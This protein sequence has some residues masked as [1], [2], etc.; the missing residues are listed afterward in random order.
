MLEGITY[1]N[2]STVPKETWD[3]AVKMILMKEGIPD[4]AAARFSL[5]ANIVYKAGGSTVLKLFPPFHEDGFRAEKAVLELLGWANVPAET[6]ELLRSSEF[7]GW[8]YL[9]M[10][11]VEGEL[12]IE[13]WERLDRQEKLQYAT[14]L[15]KLIRAVHRLD[16]SA[17]GPLPDEWEKFIRKQKDRLAAH[18][19][20]AGVPEHL[21]A[22]MPAY[23]EAAD[24]SSKRHVL[25]TGEYTPFNLLMKEGADGWRISG[26]ID[27]A[28]CFIGN[29]KYDLL[30]PI[31]FNFHMEE[32]LT[33]AFLEAYGLTLTDRLRRELMALLLI[34]RFS[35]LPAYMEGS[36]A[37]READHLTD[38][39][40]VFFPW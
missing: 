3:K 6:P 37:A 27:F 25:L 17:A 13:R 33:A 16:A 9:L 32:G 12:A 22:E 11:F 5:G 21:V 2:Y 31:L 18:H 4:E 28:D 23:L 20:A 24:L 7:E 38:L 8:P 30:G 1:S 34:H 40:G 39:A 14:D 35:D 10:S 19:R 15:G 26:L 36:Q 29:P